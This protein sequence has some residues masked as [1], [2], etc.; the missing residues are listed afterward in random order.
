MQ[1]GALSELN[2][3]NSDQ[4]LDLVSGKPVTELRGK[5]KMAPYEVLWITNRVN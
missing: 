4:W 5:I 2:L 1:T 3:M